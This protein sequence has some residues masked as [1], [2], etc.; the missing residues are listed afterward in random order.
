VL[1]AFR[2]FFLN[3]YLRDTH[4]LGIRET[5]MTHMAHGVSMTVTCYAGDTMWHCDYRKSGYDQTTAKRT[6]ETADAL[7]ECFHRLPGSC[8]LRNRDER[9]VV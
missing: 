8:H 4:I 1:I 5:V 7:A 6:G 9:G 3:L 2:V